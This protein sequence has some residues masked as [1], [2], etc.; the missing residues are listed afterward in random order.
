MHNYTKWCDHVGL[1]Q[2]PASQNDWFSK[3]EPFADDACNL[4]LSEV[5]L[6]FLIWTEGHNLRYMPELLN[7]LFWCMR[8][9]SV[10]EEA[11]NVGSS[12]RGDVQPVPSDPEMVSPFLTSLSTVY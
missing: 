6:V 9:S 7:F 10:F 2:R 1:P 12:G 4:L 3:S 11:A 5:A 8:F